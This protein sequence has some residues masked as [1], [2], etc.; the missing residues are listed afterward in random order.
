MRYVEELAPSLGHRNVEYSLPTRNSSGVGM[1]LLP[2]NDG[3]TR[4][5]QILLKLGVGDVGNRTKG[6][7][8]IRSSSAGV[9]AFRGPSPELINE[10]GR[11]RGTNPSTGESRNVDGMRP[12]SAV[13]GQVDG[14][15]IFPVSPCDVVKKNSYGYSRRVHLVP[16][17][18]SSPTRDLSDSEPN[19][20]VGLL[21]DEP[22]PTSH[23]TRG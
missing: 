11:L 13:S 9:W 19:G 8:F 23:G 20:L 5:S 3:V 18:F 7:R 2:Q 4:F 12:P 15:H 6:E 14:A 10:D 16:H 21:R 22:A 17:E 1:P